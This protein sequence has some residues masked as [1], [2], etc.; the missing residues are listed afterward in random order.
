MASSYS[1]LDVTTIDKKIYSL[2]MHDANDN[3]IEQQ[4][5]QNG[6]K[7]RYSKDMKGH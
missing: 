6:N 1:E 7:S 3:N 4:L 5:L 2:R